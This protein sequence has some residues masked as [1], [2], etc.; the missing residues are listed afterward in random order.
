LNSLIDFGAELPDGLHIGIFGKMARYLNGFEKIEDAKEHEADIDVMIIIK[1]GKKEEIKNKLLKGFES[2]K[3]EIVWGDDLDYFYHFRS[4]GKITID[5]EIHEKETVFYEQHPLLGCSIFAHYK[6]IYKRDGQ[7][8]EDLLR[9][10][11]G[12]SI[13]DRFKIL[14]DDRKGLSEFKERLEKNS[15]EI[16]PRRVVSI[17]VKNIAWAMSGSRPLNTNA[18]FEFLSNRW[19]DVFP[20]VALNDIKEMLPKSQ[21][22]I[23]KKY[24]EYKNHAVKMISDALQF[25]NLQLKE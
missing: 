7:Y 22:D 25:S 18:A 24:G 2:P 19:T 16:D 6:T 20:S 10:S 23:R 8:V 14:R 11:Y 5:I 15:V 17:C 4:K 13:N 9:L 12:F 3:I 1:S 21:S